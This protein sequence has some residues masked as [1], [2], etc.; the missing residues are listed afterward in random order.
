MRLDPRLVLLCCA[1]IPA[2]QR[3][4]SPVETA[5]SASLPPVYGLASGEDSLVGMFTMTLDP[6][7]L[8]TTVTPIRGATA[9]P[10]QGQVYDLDIA[11]FLTPSALQITGVQVLGSGNFRITFSHSHPFPAPNVAN[12]ITASNRADLG[13]TGR[14]V[15]LAEGNPQL[16]YGGTVRVSAGTVVGADGYAGFGN[17]L[18]SSHPTLVNAYPYKLLADEAKDNRVGVSN[19]GDPKGTYVPASGG[20]QR[21]NLGAS[22]TGWTGYDYLHG[23]QSITNTFVLDKDAVGSGTFALN[24][25]LV[26]QYQDP[27]GAGGKTLRLPPA[28]H[29]V[30]Q[31]AYRLPYADL[32]CSLIGAPA[33]LTVQTNVGA[34]AA[35]ALTV[36]DWDANATE[37]ADA[38]VGDETNVAL[39]QLGAS[40]HPFLEIDAPDLSAAVLDMGF[41]TGGTG[42][43][44]TPLAYDSILSNTLGTA[45]PGEHWALVRATDPENDEASRGAYH[46]GVDGNT[47]LPSALLTLDAQTF[48]LIPVTVTEAPQPPVVTG[49]SPQGIV[50][51]LD[52]FVTFSATA[53]NTPTTWT[54]DFGGGGQPNA[55]LGSVPTVQLHPTEGTYNG[56]VIAGNATGNSA[57]FAFT[58]R[59]LPPVRPHFNRVIITPSNLNTIVLDSHLLLSSSGRAAFFYSHSDTDFAVHFARALTTNP[60]SPADWA[61]H[62]VENDCGANIAGG[63]IDGRFAAVYPSSDDDQSI[64]Y[65]YATVDEPTSTSDWHISVVKNSVVGEDWGLAAHLVDYN[66][67]PAFTTREFTGDQETWYFRA[68]VTNPLLPAHWLSHRLSTTAIQSD[69]VVQNFPE[70]PR[71]LVFLNEN[72]DSKV[73]LLRPTVAEPGILAE[74]SSTDAIPFSTISTI[75]ATPGLIESGK[76]HVVLLAVANDQSVRYLDLAGPAATTMLL[77]RVYTLDTTANMFVNIAPCLTFLNGRPAVGFY[78]FQDNAFV[79]GRGLQ[80]FPGKTDW[81]FQTLQI[82]ALTRATLGVNNNALCAVGDTGFNGDG[83][84]YYQADGPW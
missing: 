5:S 50:G 33:T 68:T 80:R 6:A 64:R 15:I 23:G 1:L 41:S 51:G 13:Y 10:P 22:G 19:G 48:Q 59:I 52:D 44:D 53:T 26:I 79:V 43:S 56:T 9:Q 30:L 11:N 84:V 8:E 42:Y 63:V 20:W 34:T 16:F 29:D 2:C 71:P 49:V 7:T 73:E 55:P 37:A 65:T 54:W 39:V 46:V 70:G 21:A 3:A 81:E 74:W 32:D 40:G 82:G 66:G 35:V 67:R 62:V 58:Y 77:S 24:L 14:L 83:W 60:L 17:L 4:D 18:V 76:S 12:P 36:R 75:I 47:L 27:R 61:T 72:A 31:F 45:S 78:S 38:K 25:A 28:T 57:P 69:L